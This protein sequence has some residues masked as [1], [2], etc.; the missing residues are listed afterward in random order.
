MNDISNFPQGY[1]K[2]PSQNG[3]SWGYNDNELYRRF[4]ETRT[5]KTTDPQL[6]VLLTVSSH[7]PF[8]LNE[9][10]KFFKAFNNRLAQLGFDDEKKK[11]YQAYKNQY[12]SILYTDDAI[13]GFINN[14]K[15]REDFKNTI[16]LITGDHRMPEIPMSNKID[17][18][19]VPLIIYSPL[20]KRT[21]KIESVSTHFD[22]TPSLLSFLH[23]DYGVKQPALSIWMGN[24]LDT[25]RSFRNLHSIPLMQTKT[26]L[27]DFISGDYHLNNQTVYKISNNMEE[28]IVQDKDIFNRLNSAFNEYKS[29]NNKSLTNKRLIPDSLYKS[30]YPEK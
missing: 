12:A 26:T 28:E 2:L 19:H 30:Y 29:R 22:I 20:L 25:A 5:P 9:Q 14:Y 18:Y 16:F 15:K 10:D 21:A 27:T 6:S 4:L 13:R 1:S 17:R 24:G 23:S 3:F 11:E 8:L 7:S